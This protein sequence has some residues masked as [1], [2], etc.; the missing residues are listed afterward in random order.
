MHRDEYLTLNH[1]A[2]YSTL[3]FQKHNTFKVKLELLR[4]KKSTEDWGKTR[5]SWLRSVVFKKS[6]DMTYV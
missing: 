6:I 4:R 1:I 2:I 3:T 5:S